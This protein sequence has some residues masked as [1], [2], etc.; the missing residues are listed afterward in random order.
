VEE[1]PIV[2]PELEIAVAQITEFGFS[3]IDKIVKILKEVNGD[4]SAA[5]DKLLEDA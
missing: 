2:A 4:A 3:D 5:I 1:E